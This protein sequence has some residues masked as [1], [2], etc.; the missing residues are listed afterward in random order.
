V[1][2]LVAIARIRIFRKNFIPPYSP[3]PE[4]A[5]PSIDYSERAKVD[6]HNFYASARKRDG[7]P[8]DLFPNY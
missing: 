5:I 3:S 2:F 4:H 1:C 7:L 6:G 8:H